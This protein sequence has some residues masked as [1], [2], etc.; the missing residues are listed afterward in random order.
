MFKKKKNTPLPVPRRRLVE[1]EIEDGRQRPASVAADNGGAYN[2]RQFRRNQT[3]SS[4]KKTSDLDV[5]ERQ[6]AHQL[7]DRRRRLGG[8]FL[9]AAGVAVLLLVGLWQFI[10]QPIVSIASTE[11]TRTVNTER[12]EAAISEYV[13]RNPS[14]RFRASLDQQALSLYVSAKHSEVASVRLTEG[15]SLPSQV[16][17]TVEFRQPVVSW[18]MGGTPYFVDADG[19][20]FL[21]N[22]FELPGVKVV[23]ESGVASE[24][25]SVV[26]SSRL[27]GF[28]GRVVDLAKGR[29]YTVTEAILPP[30]STRRI[31]V[32]L[33][34]EGEARVRFTI[35]RGVGVQVEDMDTAL[36]YFKERGVALQYIDVR[37]AGRAAYK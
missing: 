3:V 26:A 19:V 22:Y 4:Y 15:V 34:E 10:A 12:Y 16:R 9:V 17:F 33:L 1:F 35:D 32:K 14:Q 18:Q 37:V 28:L 8:V 24:Q 5:S 36:R 7:V 21:E 31:D 27:L 23:D 25:G 29:G 30:D 11:V 2:S 6:K 13:E 20:V